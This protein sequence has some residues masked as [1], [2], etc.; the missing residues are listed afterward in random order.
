M[1]PLHTQLKDGLIGCS[2]HCAEKLCDGLVAAIC[3]SRRVHVQGRECPRGKVLADT[4]NARKTCIEAAHSYRA[5]RMLP[6]RETTLSGL[7]REAKR[8]AATK[9]SL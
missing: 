9:V 7:T 6:T 1:T 5:C 2:S 8:H 4:E 3:L